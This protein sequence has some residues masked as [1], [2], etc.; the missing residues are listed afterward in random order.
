M[1]LSSSLLIGGRERGE[2]DRLPTTASAT[3]TQ[4]SKEGKQEKGG[5]LFVLLLPK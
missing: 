1:C 4:Q 3:D 5:L 2:G